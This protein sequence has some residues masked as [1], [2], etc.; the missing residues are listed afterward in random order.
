[1]SKGRRARWKLLRQR[2]AALVFGER[3]LCDTCKY[4]YGDACTRAERPNA[5][6]CEDYERG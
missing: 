3:I 4:D 5:T 1:M 2:L 6:R